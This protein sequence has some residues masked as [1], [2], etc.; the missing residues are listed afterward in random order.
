[1]KP[2]FGKKDYLDIYKLTNED[3]P[4][5]I[6]C[7]KKC[8]SICCKVENDYGIY[9][10][11]GEHLV[12]KKNEPW[13]KWNTQSADDQG[14]PDSWIGPVYFLNCKGYCNRDYRPMQCRTYPVA[15]HICPNGKFILIIETLETTYTCPLI[16]QKD[17]HSSFSKEWLHNLY[18][19]WGKLLNDPLIYDLIIMDS[20]ARIKEKKEIIIAYGN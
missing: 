2:E 3:S 6:D 8:G 14:F 10:L 1:M 5:E 12:F 18:L 4:L 15:P 17:Y 7:G 19:A 20:E 13:F 16:E 9:L 11:P